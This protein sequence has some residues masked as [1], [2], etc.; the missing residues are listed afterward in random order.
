MLGGTLLILISIISALIK[1]DKLVALS[2]LCLFLWLSTILLTIKFLPFTLIFLLL[3]IIASFIL[4]YIMVKKKNYLF[5]PALVIYASIAITAYTLPTDTRYYYLSIKWNYEIDGDYMSWH[6]Y[7]WH[8]SNN[9]KFEE[10]LVASNKA[11]QLVTEKGDE[12]WKQ[13]IEEHHEKISAR[14]P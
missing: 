14:F 9:N 12:H 4:V 13:L 1:K 11:L 3:A 2:G 6:K 10:T 7:S 5:I 8:L